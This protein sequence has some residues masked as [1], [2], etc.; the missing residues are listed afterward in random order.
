MPIAFLENTP[1]IKQTFNS[2]W[3][4]SEAYLVPFRLCFRFVP[5]PR[6][7]PKQNQRPDRPKG[8]ERG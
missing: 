4:F 8:R 1:A 5:H 6:L 3:R 7:F 2:P